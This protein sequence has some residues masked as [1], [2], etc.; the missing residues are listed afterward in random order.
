M[1]V[2][3]ITLSFGGNVALDHV[4]FNVKHEQCSIDHKQN[5]YS[6]KAGMLLIA[7]N[8]RLPNLGFSAGGSSVVQGGENVKAFYRR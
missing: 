5:R 8:T 2:E 7:K 1:K 6:L 3:S 4:S